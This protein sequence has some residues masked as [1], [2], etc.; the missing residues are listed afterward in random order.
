MRFSAHP[1]FFLP[2]KCFVGRGFSRDLSQPREQGLQPL[3]SVDSENPESLGPSNNFS[4]GPCRGAALL[5][6][7]SA[8]SP[9][10]ERRRIAATE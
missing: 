4:R 5:L 8:R 1:F 6:P 10:L 7:M 2:E 3:K 9:D